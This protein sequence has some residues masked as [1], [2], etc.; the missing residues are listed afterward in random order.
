[1]SH[2]RKDIG[3]I[4][5]FVADPERAKL[6]YQEIFEL[7]PSLDDDTDVMF[8]LENTLL[9]LTKLSEAP[10][11]IAPAVAGSPDNGP[12][13]VFAIIVDDVDAVCAELTGKGVA[14]LNGPQDRSWGMRTANFPGP[15]RLCLGD[16]DGTAGAS[17]GHGSNRAAAYP[18][19]QHRLFMLSAW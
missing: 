7:Q 12:R 9:S 15:R 1:M 17:T 4:T 3:A 14:L 10:R 11:V 6:F 2:W 13:H 5:L 18:G 16:R 19:A 8:R